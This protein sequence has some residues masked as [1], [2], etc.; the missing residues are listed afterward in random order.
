MKRA[1]LIALTAS[2]IHIFLLL[3]AYL[4]IVPRIH[5][6]GFFPYREIAQGYHMNQFISSLAN[7]DGVHYLGLA[8]R[9]YYQFEQAFF[10]LY[11]LCIRGL[12]FLFNN[13]L[14][15]S[16]IVVTNI[17]FVIGF[18]FLILLFSRMENK[19]SISALLLYI[20][21][22]ASYYFHVVYTE[23]LF[24][25]FFAGALFFYQRKQWLWAGVFGFFASLTR[26]FGVLL[27][28]LFL[29]QA[30]LMYK[31]VGWRI[32]ILPLLP[33]GGFVSY[34]VFL[35]ITT[36]DPFAF[37]HAQSAF[38]TR[39]THLVLLPQVYYRYLK[40][41]FTAQFSFAYAIACL[42]LLIF[43]VCIVGCVYVFVKKCKTWKTNPLPT[44][45]AGFSILSILIP[46]F[47]GTL[48]SIPR[49][50]LFAF[51]FFIALSHLSK[52]VQFVII[53]VSLLCQLILFSFFLQ[54]YFVS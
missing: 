22:P 5:Y 40:I 26:L 43:S 18:A 10:P 51:S 54:G 44:F 19:T 38:A 29:Y 42:E 3:L 4:L 15:I 33:L 31:R 41:I 50:S 23:G 49:Y 52:R 48:S 2:V 12:G 25:C 24:L 11:P 45:L 21:F 46:T 8:E 36:G 1:V 13:N 9:G 34:A 37:F 20:A 47:T 6:S 53:A 28:I 35:L 14:L 16:G 39:S 17:A 7:F 27:T 32:F 30:Y